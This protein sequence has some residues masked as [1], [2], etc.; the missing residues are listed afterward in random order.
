MLSAAGA[1]SDPGPAS[2]DTLTS[3]PGAATC[4]AADLRAIF[5]G[6]EAAGGSLTGAVVVTEV[7]SDTCS[8]DGSPRSVGMLDDDGGI[9]PV[10]GHALDV[11]LNGGPVTLTPRAPLPAFGSPPAAG[12]AWFALSWSNWCSTDSP[13]VLSLLI[14][15]PAGGSIAAPLD[16]NIP[17]WAVGPPMPQCSDA[18]SQST[19]SYGRFQPPTSG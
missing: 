6:F 2:Q 7:G 1:C 12:S 10:K 5:R 3:A 14:V 9:V 13:T 16:A 11:P 8:L 17:S 15:L 19:L 18:H 4:H